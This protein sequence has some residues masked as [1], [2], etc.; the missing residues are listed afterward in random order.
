MAV[1]KNSAFVALMRA[2][3]MITFYSI[4]L[5][6]TGR[7][8][9]LLDVLLVTQKRAN[10]WLNLKARACFLLSQDANQAKTH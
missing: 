2:T 10:K 6:P 7:L 5:V 3:L 8:Q 4:H 1:T 9:E